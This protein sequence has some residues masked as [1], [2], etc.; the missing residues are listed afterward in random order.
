M[1]DFFDQFRQP[2]SGG[3][4]FFDQ[5]RSG[6]SSST[7]KNDVNT[8]EGNLALASQISPEVSAEAQDIA[9]PEQKLSLLQRLAHA[10]GAFNPAEAIQKTMDESKT[11]Q[12]PSVINLPKNYLKSIGEGLAAGVTGNSEY[13]AGR[14]NF[15]ELV[16]RLVP[17]HYSDKVAQ[18]LPVNMPGRDAALWLAGAGEGMGRYALGTGLDI[19]ADPTTYVGG[20]LAKGVGTVAK[21]GGK[22]AL[23]LASKVA[24]EA[25]EAGIETAGKVKDAL[26]RTFVFGHGTS[27]GVPEK[28]LELQGALSKAKEQIINE[29]KDRFA[30]LTTDQKEELVQRLL[31]G[32]RLEYKLGQRAERTQAAADKAAMDA[33]NLETSH[34]AINMEFA[35]D[36]MAPRHEA[37]GRLGT[38]HEMATT[39]ADAQAANAAKAEASKQAAQRAAIETAMAGSKKERRAIRLALKN[40]NVMPA[41]P[42]QAA[43]LVDPVEYYA[44]RAAAEGKYIGGDQTLR[45][46]VVSQIERSRDFAKQAG[47]EDPYAVYFPSIDKERLNKFFEGTSGMRI[48]SQGYKKQFQNVL[49]DEALVTNPTEAFA[50]REYEMT[51]DALTSKTQQELVSAVGKPADAFKNDAEA[52]KAGFVPIKAKGNHGEL[53][54]YLK[55]ADKKFVDHLVSPEYGSLDQLARQLGY[56]A[57]TALFK[58]SVTGLFPA[59]HVRNWLSGHIQNFEQLGKDALRPENIADGINMARESAGIGKAGQTMTLRGRQ[60]PIEMVM[61][62]FEK[63]FGGSSS[64]ISDI[65]DATSEAPSWFKHLGMKSGET[66]GLGLAGAG[67]GAYLDKDNRLRGALVGGLAGAAGGALSTKLLPQEGKLFSSARAVGNFIETAQKGTAYMTALRQGKSVQ[68][69]L[70]Q[71][72]KAG[73][74]YRALTATESKVMR[75]LFPFYS[76]TRKNVDLQLRTLKE[77]PERINQVLQAVG[78][79]GDHPSKEE[80]SSLPDYIRGGLSVKLKDTDKGVKQYIAN[81]GTALENFANTFDP[82][83][84]PVMRVGSQMNPIPKAMLDLAYGKDSFRQKDIK[85]SY[86]AREYKLLA[87]TPL[88]G[89]LKLQKVNRSYRKPNG[90]TVTREQWVADPERLYLARSLFTSRGFNTLDQ[91]FGGDMTGAVKWLRLLTGLK[92]QQVDMEATQAAEEKRRIRALQD[93]N[94]RY[95]KVATLQ[96]AFT[97]KGR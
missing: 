66:V 68:E 81:F 52:A 79:L 29:N 34:R 49:K 2:S 42:A 48:G 86:D 85:D 69:A 10:V 24:P 11:A 39:V 61:R 76:F 46:A 31:E 55:E 87:N 93:L 51:K 70:D 17:E 96:R 13:D 57:V 43:G 28:A 65:A 27:T 37:Q 20:E 16:D 91:M 21:A 64:Y 9:H 5:F 92:P 7:H 47:I 36:P 73:F 67:T 84:N 94:A 32:K 97:P 15:G 82:E 8:I 14:R 83:G 63:R 80:Q 59:F 90:E 3:G 74:D 33:A 54:G 4:D 35:E 89:L 25:V 6:G 41:L 72:A 18:M 30:G 19:A 23:K 22:G 44:R 38:A 71:A 77:H 78:E 95:G 1:P 50:R 88:A 26:G 60:V 56:D 62:P 40:Q 75:R 53:V 12:M 45:D 58:R